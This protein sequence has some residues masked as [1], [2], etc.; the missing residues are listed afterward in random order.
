MR[1]LR[2]ARHAV[3]VLVAQLADPIVTPGVDIAWERRDETAEWT[4]R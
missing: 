1:P 3:V 2:V 4:V